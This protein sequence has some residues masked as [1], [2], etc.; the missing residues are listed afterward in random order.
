MPTLRFVAWLPLATFSHPTL[1]NGDSD[2]IGE[3]TTPIFLIARICRM[4]LEREVHFWMSNTIAGA[5]NVQLPVSLG[6]L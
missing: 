3:D 6:K 2:G 4:I 5:D 1:F